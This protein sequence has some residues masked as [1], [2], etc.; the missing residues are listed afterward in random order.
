MEPC[1]EVPVT[2]NPT[3]VNPRLSGAPEI[4]LVKNEKYIILLPPM[5]EDVVEEGALLG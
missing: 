5:S 3:Y 4:H 1:K 2:W